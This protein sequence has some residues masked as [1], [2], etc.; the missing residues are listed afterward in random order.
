M[1]WSRPLKLSCSRSRTSEPRV[2][3]ST[4]RGSSF[5][6]IASFRCLTTV[7]HAVL[8]LPRCG[9]P[10]KITPAVALNRAAARFCRPWM[11]Y[12]KA[13]QSAFF[14]WSVA[15]W[16]P[17]SGASTYIFDNQSA[18]A[19]A[20]KN[21][22]T[23]LLYDGYWLSTSHVQRLT[24]YE[25]EI[26]DKLLRGSVVRAAGPEADWGRAELCRCRSRRRKTAIHPFRNWTSWCA[27]AWRRMAT[28][29]AATRCHPSATSLADGPQ[30]REQ[31]LG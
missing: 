10:R 14:Y 19:V 16:L 21:N 18:Q 20:D 17:L 3:D 15:S 5:L 26:E 13:L 30:G 23:L 25:S 31:K 28:S 6:N 29:R 11:L 27:P 22:R 8:L 1:L 24:P 9:V 7:A 12:S 2:S 4:T